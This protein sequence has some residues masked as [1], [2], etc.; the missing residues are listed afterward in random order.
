VIALRLEIGYHPRNR[1]VAMSLGSVGGG[2]ARG[3]TVIG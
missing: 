3:C 1:A 2:P